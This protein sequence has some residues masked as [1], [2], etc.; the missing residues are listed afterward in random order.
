MPPKPNLTITI[1]HAPHTAPPPPI[2]DPKRQ[3]GGKKKKITLEEQHKIGKYS[4][5]ATARKKKK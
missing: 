3:I 1:P 5:V 4:N 2:F